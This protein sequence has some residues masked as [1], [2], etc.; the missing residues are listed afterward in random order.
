MKWLTADWHGLLGTPWAEIMLTVVAVVCGTIIGIERELKNKPTG[1]RTLSLVCLGSAVFTMVSG[2][3][4]DGKIAAQIVSGIGFLGAGA[5]IHGRYAVT[6]L[7]SAATIWAVAAIG[8]LAGVG[9]AGGSLALSVL[10]IALLTVIATIEQRLLGPC[11]QGTV[12]L[13]LKDNQ[14]KAMIK[15]GEVLDEYQMPPTACTL[16]KQEGET[17]KASIRYCTAHAHHRAVLAQIADMPEVLSMHR[18]SEP[19]LHRPAKG[20]AKKQQGEKL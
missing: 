16:L 5:V 15:L 10:I 9:Y 14:G 3:V 2:M 13:T 17:L 19:L 11:H 4:S 18:E 20:L 1:T 12:T 8:M 7:T 6:G